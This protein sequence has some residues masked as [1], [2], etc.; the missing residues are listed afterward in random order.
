MASLPISH[1][2]FQAVPYNMHGINQGSPSLENIIIA[3]TP[4]VIFLQEHW[5]T[6]ASLGS[7]LNFSS[8]YRGFGIS[9]MESVVGKFVIRGRPYGGTATLINNKWRTI[10]NVLMISERTVIIP[11]GDLIL[12]NVYFP[13]VSN[14]HLEIIDIELSK[15]KNI[16]DDYPNHKIL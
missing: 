6:P 2:S 1:N 16:I 11:L 5:Q 10:I 15:I 12:I 3:T 14:N 4:D 8:L 7:I 13:C 9:V